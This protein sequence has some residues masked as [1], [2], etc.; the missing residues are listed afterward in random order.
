MGTYYA[1]ELRKAVSL[2]CIIECS[3]GIKYLK[4]AVLFYSFVREISILKG[5]PKDTK[6]NIFE[7][8]LP[9]L[10]DRLGLC[11][12]RN[13]P[14]EYR[15]SQTIAE[16]SAVHLSAAIASEARIFMY[17]FRNL[18]GNKCCY[19]DK[20]S[21]FLE[22][23][24]DPSFVHPYELGKFKLLR[25]VKEAYFISPGNYSS[26]DENGKLNLVIGGREIYDYD[27]KRIFAYFKDFIANRNRERFYKLPRLKT[28]PKSNPTLFLSY[29][30]KKR[31]RKHGV[32]L[33][34]SNPEVNTMEYGSLPNDLIYY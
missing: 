18:P 32:W 26:K 23:E 29:I 19:V 12:D 30:K 10:H 5:D 20:D 16:D 9:A 31:I 13:K 24:L 22:K 14:T 3:H 11:V 8:L 27:N 6:A 25:K 34:T 4:E 7:L 21:I 33:E 17:H 28:S 15:S 2:G 1:E